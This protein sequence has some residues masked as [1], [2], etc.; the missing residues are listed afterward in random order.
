M[1]CPESSP[2]LNSVFMYVSLW[3]LFFF[4]L[5]MTGLKCKLGHLSERGLK[6]RTFSS[7]HKYLYL[8]IQIKKQICKVD[9]SIKIIAWERY[10][11]IRKY[12]YNHFSVCGCLYNIFIWSSLCLSFWR[13]AFLFGNDQFFT[14]ILHLVQI[15]FNRC[16]L[17]WVMSGSLSRSLFFNL[18][19]V[20][21]M[22]SHGIPLES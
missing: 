21:P 3:L 15:Q 18:W 16:T 13:I 10:S 22:W 14:F 12:F 6:K 9:C 20:S 5:F 7:E 11:W 19:V 1:F 8:L 4:F 17:A 2:E